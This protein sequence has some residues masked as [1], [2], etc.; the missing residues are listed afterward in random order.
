MNNLQACKEKQV[1]TVKEIAQALDLHKE[2]KDELFDYLCNIGEIDKNCEISNSKESWISIAQALTDILQRKEEYHFP[3]P[4]SLSFE[5]ITHFFHQ[6]YVK[7]KEFVDYLCKFISFQSKV[8]E[9]YPLQ[10]RCDSMTD[11]PQS[12]KTNIDT[13]F[14]YIAKQLNEK[15][16]YKIGVTKDIQQR[17]NTFKTGNCFVEMIASVKTNF[18]YKLESLLHSVYKPFNLTR[19]WFVF[20]DE[21]LEEIISSFGFTRFIDTDKE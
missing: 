6:F 10:N 1:M 17:L 18:P 3:E 21:K 11:K 15:D 14:V 12:E 4:Q 20:S 5:E 2:L 19:E 7:E 13:G 16:V 8:Y 9:L